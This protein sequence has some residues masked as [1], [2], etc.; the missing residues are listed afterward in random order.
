MTT[1]PPTPKPTW[2]ATCAVFGGGATGT[3]LRI[4]F[5]HLGTTTGTAPHLLTWGINV[6]GAFTL[7]YATAAL[8]H[9]RNR[10]HGLRRTAPWWG[11]GLLGSFT[12]YSAMM[13]HTP[14]P[15][16]IAAAIATGVL[17]AATGFWLAH[18][19]A[20]PTGA[21]S[22]DDNPGHGSSGHGSPAGGVSLGH[23]PA[24][25]PKTTPDAPPNPPA[26]AP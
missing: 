21:H 23:P 2:A 9:N 17:G 3:G 16:L 19:T 7:A 22:E 6:A 25:R 26:G 8:A 1:P 5:D 24:A 14:H 12:T 18:R 13:L 10:L 11:T 15:G 20:R 4:G